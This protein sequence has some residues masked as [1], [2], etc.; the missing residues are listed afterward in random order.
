MNAIFPAHLANIL[1]AADSLYVAD[2]F[3]NAIRRLDP[4]TGIV[5]TI[6]GGSGRGFSDGIGTAAKFFWPRTLVILDA[7]T[8]FVIEEGNG[9]IRALRIRSRRVTTLMPTLPDFTED[10]PQPSGGAC[11]LDA[12][13][14]WHRLIVSGRRGVFVVNVSAPSQSREPWLGLSNPGGMACVE[15]SDGKKL[16]L[17]TS[18]GSSSILMLRD[19]EEKDVSEVVDCD[20]GRLPFGPRPQN[21]VYLSPRNGSA[22]LGSLFVT[23]Y[24]RHRIVRLDM[25]PRRCSWPWNRFRVGGC[26][27]RDNFAAVKPTVLIGAGGLA[28]ERVRE[29]QEER[30]ARLSFPRGVAISADGRT[31]FVSDR[32]QMIKAVDLTREPPRVQILAGEVGCG[33]VDGPGANARFW[34]ARGCRWQPPDKPS[35]GDGITGGDG[36]ENENCDPKHGC[37][38][39]ARPDTVQWFVVHATSRTGSTWLCDLLAESSQVFITPTR[40][41]AISARPV[42][43]MRTRRSP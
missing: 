42:R 21:I 20:G 40:I 13:T 10:A 34:L 11:L 41:A 37:A 19:G 43:T 38:T 2:T 28:L 24:D 15:Q 30:T 16:V 35:E 17:V 29:Q 14:A 9:A 22:L 4:S 3:N 6:A 7:S 12:Y 1:W 32:G 27:E 33:L 18:L 31:L 8:L 5:S 25:C 39:S 23:D 36:G 26:W